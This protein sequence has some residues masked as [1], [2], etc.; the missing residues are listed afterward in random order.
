MEITVAPTFVPKEVDPTRS[1][2]RRLGAVIVR[3][4]FEPLFD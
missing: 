1:D 4:D 2:T 3:A